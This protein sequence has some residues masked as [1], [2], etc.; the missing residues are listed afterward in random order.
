MD[1]RIFSGIVCIAVFLLIFSGI[2]FAQTQSAPSQTG[3][4]TAGAAPTGSPP[5]GTPPSGAAPTG[6]PPDG[7]FV[8]NSPHVGDGA[9][10]QAFID[11]MD[12]NKDGKIDHDEWE[13]NKIKTV[14]K[15]KRW[16][17]Y[18]KNMDQYITVDEAPQKGVNW[19]AAPV[20]VKSTTPNTN[21]IAFIAKFDKNQDGKVD[22]T[23]FTGV[24]FPVYDANSDG[25]IEPLEAPAGQTAY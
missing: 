22:N 15:E 8:A 9:T 5:A 2:G 17:Q 24:H 14:Y 4:P 11:L 3:T 18:N 19:E 25:F 1:K 21:Q 10:G 23:E 7:G 13:A 16:P 20:E 6:A 12:T